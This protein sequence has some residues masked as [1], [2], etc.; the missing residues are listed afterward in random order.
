MPR[1]PLLLA[2]LTTA[3]LISPA[4]AQDDTSNRKRA[5]SDGLAAAMADAMP[6]YNPPPPEPEKTEEEL[7][8]E[9]ALNQPQNEIIR[10]PRMIVEGERP[11]V[12]TEREINTDKGLQELAVKRYFS[13]AAQA[14]NA[15][16][17]PFLGMSKEEIAMRMW[18]E[19]ERLRQMTDFEERATMEEALGEDEQAKE[20]R[21]LIRDATAR[22]DTATPV[23][24]KNR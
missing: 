1:F 20:T 13:D 12:F 24:E 9:E 4:A 3:S 2:L 5:V 6:K 17:I 15:V 19:D 21:R 18:E 7:A 14:L 11:P 10:L 8:E 23:Y 22:S 16:S